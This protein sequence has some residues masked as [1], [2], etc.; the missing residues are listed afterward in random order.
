MKT[1]LVIGFLIITLF[2][3]CDKGIDNL[4]KQYAAKIIGF[5]I[6]CSTCTLSFPDDSIAMRKL[7]GESPNNYYQA[8]N[9]PKND[10]HNR[11]NA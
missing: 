7:L 1:V 9:L 2:G 8:V 11:P 4:D 3:G 10:F 6:N 5:D